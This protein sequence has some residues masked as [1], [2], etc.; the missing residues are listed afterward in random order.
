MDDL[1]TTKDAFRAMVI[2]LDRY[3]ERGNRADSLENVL[4]DISNTLWADGGP[5]D[6]AQ[7]SD[8]LA[9]VRAASAE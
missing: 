6:P 7:W 8:W 1:I 4:G 9:A 3:Y 2:F 5:N